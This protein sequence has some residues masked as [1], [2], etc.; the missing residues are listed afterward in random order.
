MTTRKPLATQHQEAVEVNSSFVLLG[1]GVVA[2]VG[3]AGF[4]ATRYRISKPE[5][6]LVRTGLGIEDMIVARKGFVW[7]FQQCT[8]SLSFTHIL[9]FSC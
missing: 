4:A 2:L 8:Y 5:E 1:V 6:Y 3:F 7:P 9:K